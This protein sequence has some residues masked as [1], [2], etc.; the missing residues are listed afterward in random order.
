MHK[1]G[2]GLLAVALSVHAQDESRFAF[3][4]AK[5][6]FKP[7]ALLDLR[8][9]NEKVAGESGFVKSDGKGGFVR[10]DEEPL[11]FWAVGSFVQERK[12][13][14]QRPLWF[15]EKTEPSLARHAR[16]LAKHGV[17]LARMHTSLNPDTK[18]DKDAKLESLDGKTRD[19]IWEF[20]AA[21]KQEGI[22]SMLTPYWANA[23]QPTEQMGLGT[24][25]AHALLFFDPR[26]KAA[27]K[28]WLRELLTQPN[29]HTGV[30]LAQDPALAIIQIQNEDATLF[31]TMGH[32]K[33]QPMALLT[34]QFS[35]WVVNKYGGAEAVANAWGS[36]AAKGDDVIGAKFELLHIYELTKD[37]PPARAQRLA[38]QTEFWSR[39]MFDFHREIVDFLRTECR[40]KQLISAGNWHTADTVRL[41]DAL[42]WSYTATDI[43]GVNRYFPG[44]HTGEQ[45]DWTIKAGHLF[46]SRSFLTNPHDWPLQLK[47]PVNQPFIITESSW[48]FPNMTASEG[49][50]LIAAYQSLTGFDA[51]CWFAFGHEQWAPPMS[52]NGYMKD[53]QEKFLCAYPDCLGQFPAAALIVRRGYVKQGEP[54]I[55][56]W[57]SLDD[58]WQRKLPLVAESSSYKSDQAD[59]RAFLVGPVEVEYG[60]EAGKSKV[61]DISAYVEGGRIRSKT[62]ELEL[63][64]ESRCFTLNAPCAQ[65]VAAF[66]KEGAQTHVLSDVTIRGDNAYGTCVAVSLDGKRLRESTQVLV[67]AGTTSRPAGWQDEAAPP[68]AEVKS[69]KG[70][71]TAASAKD[72]RKITSVGTGRGPWMMERVKMRVELTNGVVSKATALDPNGYALRPVDVRR[73]GGKVILE[74]PEDALHVILEP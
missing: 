68:S 28:G 52:G 3:E 29:P 38:D 36:A 30:P 42:R 25:N 47:L 61:E 18:A 44:V 2:L 5:D 27:Y 50:L 45:A 70:A 55:R 46:H 9:L 62:G 74:L 31:W 73:E 19:Y 12:P 10:G 40:C 65:G 23:F 16:F 21:M 13:W 60:A 53:T 51:F 1:F 69:K 41:N 59:P 71:S 24:D 48:T 17:N 11:R 43:Q 14:A 15:S 6:E 72:L 54:V 66:F 35:D 56:E 32:L 67:Q 20:V 39:L 37:A 4:P 33:P 57:R 34:M 7:D 22:Y 64:T 8:S 49:P 63:N 58:L 26:V